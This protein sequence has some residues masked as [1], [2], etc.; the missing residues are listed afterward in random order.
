MLSVVVAVLGQEPQLRESDFDWVERHIGVARDYVM[1]MGTPDQVAAYRSTK[2]QFTDMAES[3]FS[4]NRVRHE[5]PSQIETYAATIT[6]PAGNYLKGTLFGGSLRGQLRELHR[7]DS[8]ASLEILV[9]RMSIRRTRLTVEQCPAITSR[10]NALRGLS[11][12]PPRPQLS[13]PLHPVHHH[14]IVKTP[15]MNINTFFIDTGVGLAAWA[16]DTLDELKKCVK[17]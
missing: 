7:A 6:S 17:P 13:I 15:E 16:L 14:V 4:I 1:P 9:L 3:Y 10:L 11:I 2:D 8:D 12:V 5:S